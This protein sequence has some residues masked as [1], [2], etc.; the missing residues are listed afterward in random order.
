MLVELVLCPLTLTGGA[1]GSITLKLIFR[2]PS[3]S[4]EPYRQEKMGNFSMREVFV[5]HLSWRKVGLFT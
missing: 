1:F 5:M 3:A 2:E 4:A